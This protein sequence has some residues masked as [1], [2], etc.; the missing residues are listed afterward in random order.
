MVPLADFA[1]FMRL[2]WAWIPAPGLDVG[3]VND[4]DTG[5]K[6]GTP[7]S[8]DNDVSNS[9]ALSRIR[10]QFYTIWARVQTLLNVMEGGGSVG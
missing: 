4:A 9:E 2:N 6:E 3:E 10:E 8:G 1:E 7:V 5:N